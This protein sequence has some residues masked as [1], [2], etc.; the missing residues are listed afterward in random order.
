M[1]D[2]DTDTET[3]TEVDTNTTR[4]HDPHKPP[5]QLLSFLAHLQVSY[6]ASYIAPL[7]VPQ[8]QMQSQL[9]PSGRPVSALGPGVGEINLN[10][11]LNRPTPPPR[12][13]SLTVNSRPGSAAL[14]TAGRP[15]HPS[16]FPPHTPH[17]VPSAVGADRQ[18]VQAQ[19]TP[20]RA[21]VWGEGALPGR[22]SAVGKDKDKDKDKE[23]D[24]LLVVWREE[25]R[26]WVVV[27]KMRV[28]VS[29]WLAFTV[30]CRMPD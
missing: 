3:A 10:D 6:D 14:G 25:T 22:V 18:Y 9:P 15:Q 28:A 27:F 16:I 12:T 24:S 21:G 23:G 5:I 2:A 1:N 13:Q 17:P 19:G 29:E 7:P 26:E 30:F 20:L 11:P 8:M 4:E